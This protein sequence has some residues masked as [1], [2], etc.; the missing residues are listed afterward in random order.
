M[1]SRE[2]LESAFTPG[3]APA[4]GAV[5]CYEGIFIRDHWDELTTAPWWTAFS[6]DLARQLAWRRDV[7][8][9]TGQDW[10][11]L[12][13]GAT[14]AERDAVT[15]DVD[16]ESVF[17]VDRRTGVRAPLR[18]PAV[19]GWNPNGAVESNHSR[20]NTPSTY[21]E[22]DALCP[23]PEPFDKAVFQASGRADLADALIREHKTLLPCGYVISPLWHA[24]CVLGF[25]SFMFLLAENPEL[26]A[27]ASSRLLE[28]SL[29]TVRL[30]AALG[31]KAIW[32]EECM[33]DM[34]SPA[35][36]QRLNVPVLRRLCDEIRALGMHSVY[37][38][39][40]G[41][42][43]R[44][45]LILDCGADAVSFEDSKKG[46]RID[47]EAVAEAVNGRCTLLGNLDAIGL[48]EHGSEQDL[49]TE[50]RRQARAGRRNHSRFFYSL[51]SPV[52]PGT[53]VS[54]VR[55]YTDLAHEEGLNEGQSL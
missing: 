23:L 25:E 18:K 49:R 45:N 30:Q 37:Y 20:G 12:P 8:R 35:L 14:H 10:F 19:S 21:S 43:D 2:K 38:Y 48:L 9:A 31:A 44:L 5:L 40:G 27:F 33:T 32:I 51:G 41:I 13:S 47:I 6:P 34:I 50:L 22:I 11:S 15:L 17:R 36:F 4:F 52:T 7:I 54:R 26:M 42:H 24:Q 16:G 28:A 29:H 39:C 3:G 53:P 55:L 1:T 46:F